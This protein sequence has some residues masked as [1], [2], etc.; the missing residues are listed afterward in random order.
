MA[1][2]LPKKLRLYMLKRALNS[3]ISI[4]GEVD[5]TILYQNMDLTEIQNH[6]LRMSPS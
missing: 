4:G 6:I 3:L 5:K 1:A 2:A